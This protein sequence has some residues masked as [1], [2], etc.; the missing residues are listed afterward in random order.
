MS[1][2]PKSKLKELSKRL[3]NLKERRQ[4]LEKD[5][6]GTMRVSFDLSAEDGAALRDVQASYKD[7]QPSASQT[8]KMLVRM[9][10]EEWRKRSQTA[11]DMPGKET[12][13]TE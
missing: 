10:L 3:E 13:A 9:G 12:P 4:A 6:R 5:A 8:A 11:S 2:T 1:P 7:L